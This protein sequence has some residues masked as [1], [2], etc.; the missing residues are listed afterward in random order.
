MFNV[1]VQLYSARGDI[2][3]EDIVSSL[4]IKVDL[5]DHRDVVVEEKKGLFP[6][7]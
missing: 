1:R 6:I 4:D 3:P 7:K 5:K 2:V